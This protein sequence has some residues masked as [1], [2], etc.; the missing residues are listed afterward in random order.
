LKANTRLASTATHF[1]LFC[2][3]F[4]HTAIT[5]VAISN[6]F[7]SL[8]QDKKPQRWGQTVNIQVNKLQDMR[9]GENPHQSARF[10]RHDGAMPAHRSRAPNSSKA[11]NSPSTTSSMPIAALSTVLEFSD[12]ATVAIKHNNPCGVRPVD[13]IPRR[14]FS[15]SQGLRSG[16]HIWR[17]LAFNR[18]GG[19]R[20]RF[21]A[22]RNFSRDRHR[23]ELFKR[24]QGR[25]VV[26][27]NDCLISAC[28]NAT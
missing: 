4:Q 21:G 10:L 16:F 23:A 9:Y 7:S 22:Q 19:R 6:Y 17:R 2:K 11:R 28:S 8:D 5:M 26:R 12:I 24:S 1:R 14:L 18:A 15:Q 27:K 13:K 25:A 20:D 3:A